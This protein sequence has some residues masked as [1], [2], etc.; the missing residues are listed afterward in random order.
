M[1]TC[2]FYQGPE[3]HWGGRQAPG[4]PREQGGEGAGG[5]HPLLGKEAVVFVSSRRGNP[6]RPLLRQCLRLPG[7]HVILLKKELVLGKLKIDLGLFSH[8]P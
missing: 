1:G 2:Y 7:G 6:A 3:G 8:W 5:T 4:C